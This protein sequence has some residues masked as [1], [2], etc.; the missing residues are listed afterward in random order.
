MDE[1]RNDYIADALSEV[2]E[3]KVAQAA[4]PKRKLTKRR[5][6][7]AVAAVLVIV[8]IANIGFI[9]GAIS[10]KAV[11]TA[12]DSRAPS[13]NDFEDFS[14]YWA[15]REQL[16]DDVTEALA[17]LA[18]FFQE[19]AAL[20][21][22]DSGSENRIWSPVNAY[23]ALATLA[24]VT[25]G[26]SRRQILDA[27]GTPDLSTLR[28][29]V[30]ALWEEVYQDDGKEISILANSLWLSDG[31]SYNQQTMDDLSYYYYTSIYQ[32]DLNSK[33]AT[34]ALQTWLNNN[35]G[36]LLKKNVSTSSFP[37]DAV[38]TLASTVYLQS[39]WVDEFSAANNTRDIFHAPSGDTT[40]TY[41]NKK[42]TKT[43]YY[44][45]ESYG[46]VALSLKNGCKMWFI[47]PDEDKTVDDVLAQG[48]YLEHILGAMVYE[49]NDS[50]RYVK[51]NLSVPKFDVTSS[52]DL[53]QMLQSMGI[54]DIFDLEASDFTAITSD[55]P[56]TITAVNQAARV[57]IDEQGVKAASYIELPGAGAAAPPEEIIDFILNRPFLFVIADSSG[58]PLFTGVVNNP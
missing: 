6:L 37:Q 26:N 13:R 35:T 48:Q 41:M 52:A 11:S 10:A 40:V 30:S 38:L 21:M 27:L 50:Q 28:S 8:L 20:Y 19:S 49:D 4:L 51:A 1:T 15:L 31:L 3:D 29:Q 58:I 32:T 7:T 53:T 36:G 56:V 57:I 42:E 54:T 39:K 24:E 43:Y 25:G 46:A 9:P 33:K 16:E 17:T 2:S 18:P 44:W 12:S 23:I 22:S 5:F 14:E 55:S 34:T 45:G 47:L